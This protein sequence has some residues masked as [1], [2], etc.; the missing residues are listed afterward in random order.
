MLENDTNF[1]RLLAE[2][3]SVGFP[4]LMPYSSSSVLVRPGIQEHW[5]TNA[6]GNNQEQWERL[7]WKWQ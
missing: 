3:I 4:K 2:I 5:D 7:V 1:S 6:A